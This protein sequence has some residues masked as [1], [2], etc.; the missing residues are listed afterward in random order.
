MELDPTEELWDV[1]RSETITA[2][3]EQRTH[4]SY[5]CSDLGT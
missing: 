4:S 2:E 1:G 3:E 5:V